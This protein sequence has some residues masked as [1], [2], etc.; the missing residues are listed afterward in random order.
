MNFGT[1]LFTLFF[2]R[3]VGRDSFGNRYYEERRARRG[4]RLRRWVAYAGA[5]EA[6]MVPPEWHA[7]L[8]YT[9]EAPLTAVRRWP[10]QRP[11]LPNLTGTALSYRPRGHDYR[12]GHRVRAAGDYEAW[13]PDQP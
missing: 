3:L 6:S 9:T 11:H 4:R 1:W 12:G 10:W 7:W 2:G 8:H 5:A 13:A